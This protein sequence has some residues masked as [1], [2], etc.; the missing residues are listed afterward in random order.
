[1]EYKQ[2]RKMR[3]RYLDRHLP[4]RMTYFESFD[5]RILRNIMYLRKTGNGGHDTYNDCIIMADT[6]TSKKQR[7]GIA[8]NHV[9]AWTISIRAFD[10]NLVTLWGR[11]PSDLAES[12][13][14][15]CDQMAGEYTYVYFHNLAY[16]WVF[17]RRFLFRVLDKPE[18]Q[19]NV[20]PH[21]PIF[22]KFGNGLILRDSLI[23]AQR[24]LEKWADDLEVEHRKEVGKWDYDKL[25]GQRNTIPRT[26]SII[27]SMT[28]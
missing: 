22:V 12:L 25:R 9:V 16:D 4:Y 7:R 15:I 19:L 13:K 17:I 11:K 20:K 27:S 28:H 23:L 24:K 5:F 21:Y 3:E 18:K 10:R 8:E 6:E 14:K 26:S 2:L 1:M